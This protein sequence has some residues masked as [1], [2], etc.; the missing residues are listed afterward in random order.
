MRKQKDIGQ[1]KLRLTG[2]CLWFALK[3]VFDRKAK[4][5][6]IRLCKE[7][8]LVHF[9]IQTKRGNFIHIVGRDKKRDGF[10]TFF[11][12]IHIFHKSLLFKGKYWKSKKLIT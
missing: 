2:A 1:P 3:M 8:T 6:Y 11:S 5:L 7:W 9:L 10:I 12:V 4:Y